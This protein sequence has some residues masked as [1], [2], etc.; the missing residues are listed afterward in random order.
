M[1]SCEPLVTV[2]S[3]AS[4]YVA[5]FYV[6]LFKDTLCGTKAVKRALVDSMRAER[7]RQSLA[8]FSVGWEVCVG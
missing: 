3:S 8:L 2:L 4:Q 5:L 6:F 1:G 7:G